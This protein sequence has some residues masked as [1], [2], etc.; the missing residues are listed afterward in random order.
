M[1]RKDLINY[2]IPITQCIRLDFEAFAIA[3]PNTQTVCATDNFR[4]SGAANKVPIICGQN[5]GQHSKFDFD[6]IVI[7]INIA[8]RLF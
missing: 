2:C 3:G 5:L 4:V 7:I 6:V 1:Y 8:V